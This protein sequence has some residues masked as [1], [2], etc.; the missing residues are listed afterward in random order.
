[1]IGCNIANF[2]IEHCLRVLWPFTRYVK[3]HLGHCIL[4]EVE[5]ILNLISFRTNNIIDETPEKTPI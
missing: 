3:Y 5:A 4:K 2:L 1:V